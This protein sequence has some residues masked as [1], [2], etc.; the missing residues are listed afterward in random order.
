MKA[1]VLALLVAAVLAGGAYSGRSY[2]VRRGSSCSFNFGCGVRNNGGWERNFDRYT[3]TCSGYPNWLNWD[4]NRLWGDVPRGWS[5]KFAV[6]VAYHGNTHGEHTYWIHSDDVA[7]Y[8]GGF[9]FPWWFE[10]A[11]TVIGCPIVIPEQTIPEKK[12]PGVHIKVDTPDIRIPKIEI[13]K[14]Q[15]NLPRVNVPTVHTT[16]EWNPLGYDCGHTNWVGTAIITEVGD[17]YCTLDN[18]R[19]VY[20]ANCSNRRYRG[21]WKSFAVKDKIDYEC[22]DDGKR[23][24]FKRCDWRA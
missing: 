14:I 23:T 13:P 6:K 11:N 10:G 24:W 12:I 4:G 17:N 2:S 9:D 5:G 18:G 1:I 3:Y 22:Y 8:D 21:G 15:V 16:I 7:D 19:T 20:F